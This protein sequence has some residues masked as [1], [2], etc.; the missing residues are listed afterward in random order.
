MPGSH[1]VGDWSE[2][3]KMLFLGPGEAGK[4]SGMMS[5][6]KTNRPY[7]YI[8]IEH[9]GVIENGKENTTTT[10]A[11]GWKGALENYTFKEVGNATQVL[12]DTDTLEEYGE[13]FQEAW[14]KALRKLKELAEA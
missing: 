1:F 13:M 14:P 11:Q 10:E 2:G 3:S 5:R 12:V 6:I 7:E 9:L 4:M 8:S